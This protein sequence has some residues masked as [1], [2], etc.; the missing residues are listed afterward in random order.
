MPGGAFSTGRITPLKDAPLQDFAST[1][2]RDRIERGEDVAAMLDEGVAAYIRRKGLWSP[3]T[4][5]AALT[6]RIDAD[7]EAMPTC[8]SNAASCITDWA[9]GAALNDFNRGAA[10]ST[11]GHACR[12]QGVARD[13]AGDTG[14][15]IQR[16]IQPLK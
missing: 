5:M 13:G 1:D 9:S 15:P 11:S 12:S 16:Y 4:R 10:L 14:I 7:P 8:W 6:T 3:A 2:M